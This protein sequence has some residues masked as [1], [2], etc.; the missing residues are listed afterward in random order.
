M[1]IATIMN[2]KNWVSYIFPVAESEMYFD[3]KPSL[4]SRSLSYKLQ[5]GEIELREGFRGWSKKRFTGFF[6]NNVFELTGPFGHKEWTLITG[7]TIESRGE[8]TV[9]YLSFRLSTVQLVGV[10]A[11]LVFY[12]YVGYYYVGFAE[13]WQILA[14][15]VLFLYTVMICVFHYQISRIKNWLKGWVSEGL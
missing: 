5:T 6:S 8:G 11:M 4:V 13:F 15:Q 3:L 12:F 2:L 9:I 7:G 14:A 10:L 1:G